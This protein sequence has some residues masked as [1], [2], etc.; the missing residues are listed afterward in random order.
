MN[1]ESSFAGENSS[2]FVQQGDDT[3]PMTPKI[4]PDETSQNDDNPLRYYSLSHVLQL[5]HLL[6]NQ[7]EFVSGIY[8]SPNFART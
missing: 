7:N 1:D 4:V 6:L 2:I 8:D 5:T 3:Y